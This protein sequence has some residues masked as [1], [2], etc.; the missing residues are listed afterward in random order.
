MAKIKK[1][2]LSAWQIEGIIAALK[3]D[4]SGVLEN[5]GREAIIAL[6]EKSEAV[7]LKFKES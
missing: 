6:L 2:E 1:V 5:S 4:G 7:V 3:A